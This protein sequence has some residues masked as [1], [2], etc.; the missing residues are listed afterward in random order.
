MLAEDELNLSILARIGS[1][2]KWIF[3]P[4]G[5][6]NWQATVAS[7]TGL[8]AK[9]NIVGTMGILYGTGDAPVYTTLANS[10]TAVSGYAFL[11][12]N[13]LCAPCF[14][15]MGAIRREMNN[16]KWTAFAIG[17]MC[18]FAYVISLIVFQIG[19]LFVGGIQPVGLIVAAALL[20]LLLW[21]LFK[22]Y[23]EATHLTQKV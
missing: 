14:A 17:Y 3:A 12:F 11:A 7:I 2:I 19:K 4:L 9:E 6:G 1:A 15:A 13:L 21:Q 5:F 8:V 16:G 20:A 10:F 22:P 18:V 23:K